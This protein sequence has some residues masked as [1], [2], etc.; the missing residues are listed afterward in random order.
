[1]QI[2]A[3]GRAFRSLVRHD[4]RV[5]IG[6]RH[7]QRLVRHLLDHIRRQHIG[8]GQAE[9]DVSTADHFGQHALVGLLRIDRLPAIHQRI[10]A[11]MHHAVDIADPDILAL[12]A[13]RH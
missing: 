8:R 11:F 2:I 9:E 4:L 7:H 12:R 13:E 10:A 3:S 6:Q 5:R 1:M